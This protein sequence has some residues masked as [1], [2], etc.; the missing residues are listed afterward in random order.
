M[1]KGCIR[2][3]KG[4][5]PTFMTSI[6][7]PKAIRDYDVRLPNTLKRM[8]ALMIDSSSS[9]SDQELFSKTDS[10][11]FGSSETEGDKF[12]V[13]PRYLNVNPLFLEDSK[14]G[15][16]YIINL[17]SYRMSMN[18]YI[19]SQK[20]KDDLDRDWRKDYPHITGISMSKIREQKY[21]I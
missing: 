3:I 7:M 18:P 20:L 5:Y 13:E 1:K 10:D 9:S 16:A 15:H 4:G 2:A 19:N 14:I 11:Y 6:I 8:N 12:D 21:G 17:T